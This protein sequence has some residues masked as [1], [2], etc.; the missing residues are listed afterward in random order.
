MICPNLLLTTRDIRKTF[1]LIIKNQ[2][3]LVPSVICTVIIH[4]GNC[5]FAHYLQLT[6]LISSPWQE[7]KK[8]IAKNTAVKV[9]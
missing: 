3:A 1:Q 9:D 4:K 5:T 8:G 6:N 7:H 2:S